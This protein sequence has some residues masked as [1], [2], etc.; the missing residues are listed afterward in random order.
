[1]GTFLLDQWVI[2]LLMG[3]VKVWAVES[4]VT[5]V[6]RESCTFQQKYH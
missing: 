2:K 5:Q 4:P 3:R 6:G 1:M